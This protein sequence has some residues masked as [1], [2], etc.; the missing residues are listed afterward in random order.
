MIPIKEEGGGVPLNQSVIGNPSIPTEE[1][2]LRPVFRQRTGATG[3]TQEKS[4]LVAHVDPK[5]VPN[6][7]RVFPALEPG[8]TGDGL[9]AI[10]GPC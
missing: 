4:S 1:Q 9:L 2:C 3:E 5:L 10:F 6:R 7:P 8:G